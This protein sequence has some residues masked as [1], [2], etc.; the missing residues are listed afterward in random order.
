M[1]RDMPETSRSTNLGEAVEAYLGAVQTLGRDDFTRTYPHPFLL[2]CVTSQVD[3]PASSPRKTRKLS[4]DSLELPQLPEAPQLHARRVFSLATLTE[5]NPMILG[6]DEDVPLRVEGDEV[7][8][9]HGRLSIHPASGAVLFEELGSTNGTFVNG[10]PVAAGDPI[11]LHDGDILS[12]GGKRDFQFCLAP[13]FH[14][15]LRRQIRA[16]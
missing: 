6:R 2:E 7:S 1:L 4:L 12:I 5:D 11:T 3:A 14:G 15:L 8:L 9:R 16:R 13:T 10:E